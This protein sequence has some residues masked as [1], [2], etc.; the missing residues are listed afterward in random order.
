[1]KLLTK[2][3]K[4]I[5]LNQE[6]CRK[7]K[8]FLNETNWNDDWSQFESTQNIFAN[9]LEDCLKVC[10][11]DGNPPNGGDAVRVTL[12]QPEVRSLLHLVGARSL[13]N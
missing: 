8:V 4:Y 6:N 1:M 7:L 13:N 3:N 11:S 5:Y 12:D 10:S 2:P 9:L